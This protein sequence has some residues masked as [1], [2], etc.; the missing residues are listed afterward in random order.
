MN[1]IFHLSSLPVCVVLA[2]S[3]SRQQPVPPVEKGSAPPV[4]AGKVEQVYPEHRYVLI[5]LAGTVYEPGTVLIS[6]SQGL[7]ENRRVANLI[8]TEE[9][10]GRSRIPADIRSG[11]VET[12]D[13]VFLYRN[14][15]VP[16]SSGKTEGP[17][18]P[19]PE[20]ERKEITPP[21]SPDG[22]KTPDGL[23]PLPGQ[24]VVPEPAAATP[25]E[26]ENISRERERI[27]RELDRI[28]KKMDDPWKEFFS[29]KAAG[30]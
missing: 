27:R 12:G 29:E 17:G 5:T 24:P 14:M 20:A 9:R 28:P 3:C 15:A 11:S 25:E 10:M 8:V 26:R 1:R 30:K 23:L 6:Q 7:E 4:Y 19:D 21:I 18:N 13:L 2:F 16:E 22:G